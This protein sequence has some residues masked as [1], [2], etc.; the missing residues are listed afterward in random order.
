MAQG[1]PRSKPCITHS[2]VNLCYAIVKLNRILFKFDALIGYLFE[3]VSY[4]SLMY[5]LVSCTALCL[6]IMTMLQILGMRYK[7]GE[8]AALVNGAVS[9]EDAL[10]SNN[11]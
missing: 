9:E 1:I 8:D 5:L 7:A 6:L 10:L 2:N 3:N 4:M 11:K